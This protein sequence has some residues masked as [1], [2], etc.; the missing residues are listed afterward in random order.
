MSQNSNNNTKIKKADAI[1]MKCY[2]IIRK[3]IHFLK[4]W[5]LNDVKMEVLWEWHS[6]FERGLKWGR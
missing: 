1:N 5:G 3:P 6:E 4:E 2:K